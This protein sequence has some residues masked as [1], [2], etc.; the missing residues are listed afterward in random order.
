MCAAPYC[1]RHGTRCSHAPP[2]AA[3]APTPRRRC[4]PSRSR[5]RPCPGCA[6]RKARAHDAG[7][8]AGRELG[9]RRLR[10]PDARRA[11]GRRPRTQAPF[12]LSGGAGAAG[13]Q[14]EA[15]KAQAIAFVS[16]R[17]GV[18]L[19][20]RSP[21][22]AATRRR[23]GRRGAGRQRERQL[24][25]NQA[26]RALHRQRE[27]QRRL[28]DR[29]RARGLP[30]PQIQLTGSASGLRWLTATGHGGGGRRV[31][32]GLPVLPGRG[33]A[34]PQGL[35]RLPR[36]AADPA[37]PTHV[38]TPSASSPTSTSSGASA[39]GTRAA[40]DH[41]AVDDTAPTR[42]SPT[43]ADRTSSAPGRRAS[44]EPGPAAP[45]GT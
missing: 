35:R 22:S 18:E 36:A 12:G 27:A 2:P 26:R 45:I 10:T 11:P 37:G 25:I 20:L 21:S 24:P 34:L 32:R 8:D 1:R 19:T 29:D 28:E 9:P 40:G 41:L 42:P 23:Q 38:T 30:L 14:L 13:A 5:W 31:L 43:R 4:R 7:G 33:G 6:R 44:T 39:L 16:Q 15:V 17:A 3:G